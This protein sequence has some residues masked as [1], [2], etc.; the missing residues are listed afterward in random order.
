MSLFG[1]LGDAAAE[2]ASVVAQSFC[3]EAE[4]EAVGVGELA[5]GGGVAGWFAGT[6]GVD[7]G[8]VFG[9]EGVEQ[10]VVGL[11]GVCAAVDEQVGEVVDGL[12][13][14]FELYFAHFDGGEQQSADYFSELLLLLVVLGEDE[15]VHVF[16]DGV[17]GVEVVLDVQQDAGQVGVDGGELFVDGADAEFCLFAFAEDVVVA[18][19][20]FQLERFNYE[21]E[22][23]V[24]FLQLLAVELLGFDQFLLDCFAR[25]A[26]C[27]SQL[28]Y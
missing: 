10:A 14:A 21:G 8:E 13:Y 15:L 5:V 16:V 27:A 26:D 11:R 22:V 17:D 7:V 28:A 20:F 18:L 6:E 9:V 25:V 3:F 4:L 23:V 19:V 12:G 24:D 2:G 1:G